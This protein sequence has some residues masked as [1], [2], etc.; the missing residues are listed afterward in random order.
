MK[1]HPKN[2]QEFQHYKDRCPPW[3]K[4]HRDLLNDRLYMCLPVASKALAPLLWLLAC[5]S[6]DGSF[7]G[8]VDELVWRLRMPK[9]EIESGLQALLDTGFFVFDSGDAGN[10]LAD[11]LQDATPEKRRE[12]TEH[13]VLQAFDEFWSAYPK[14]KAKNEAQ[15]SWS[16][17]KVD[18]DL[19]ATILKAIEEQKQSS[20][21]QKEAGKFIPYPATWLNGHRWDD[22]PGGTGISES[23]SSLRNLPGML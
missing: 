14:K 12:E 4:L 9:K 16:K 23:S 20:E 22:E 7:D 17:L 15:K 6:K 19:L 18:A 5:E 21:W 1:L 8:S 3:I 10:A 13:S 11:C 2:W